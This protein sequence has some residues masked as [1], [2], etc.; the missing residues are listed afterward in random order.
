MERTA[1][2]RKRRLLLGLGVGLP[3]V[4][5]L[6]VVALLAHSFWSGPGAPG[7]AGAAA[8]STADPAAVAE[9]MDR[10]RQ[11]LKQ[12]EPGAAE[13]ILRAGLDADPG[14]Q[15]MRMLY[16]ETLLTLGKA[17]EAYRQY[18]QAIAI[19]PDNAELRFAAGTVASVAGMLDRAE[20]NYARAQQLAPNNPKH[21]LYLGQVLR[22]LGRIDE[23]K[24]AIL[25]AAKLDPNMAYAWGTLAGIAL[26]ENK[27]SIAETYIRKARDA[28]PKMGAW[29]LLEAKVLRRQG[30]PEDAVRLLMALDESDR[31]TDPNVLE[32]LG[33]SLGLMK[34]PADAAALYADAV[35]RNPKDKELLYQTALWY[36]RAGMEDAAKVY[37]KRAADLGQP[38][39]KKLADGMATGDGSR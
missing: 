17:R 16:G 2:L 8:R 34:R 37:A 35:E 20:E 11:R 3:L 19:G 27:L 22:K 6:A 21:P 33:L 25:T 29:R 39:A 26:D 12:N 13:S 30:K 7:S 15:D 9:I 23:A 28:D 32:E 24:A 4:I 10:A 38:D 5:V 1:Q 36:Q 31:L 18:E 14:N